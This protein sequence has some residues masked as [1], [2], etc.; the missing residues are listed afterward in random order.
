MEQQ[1]IIYL[2]SRYREGLITEQEHSELRLILSDEQH[3]ELISETILDDMMQMMAGEEVDKKRWE[4]LLQ[5]ILDIDT[6]KKHKPT[7]IISLPQESNSWDW[8]KIA[9]AAAVLLV[10]GVG[11]WFAIFDIKAD[12]D[13]I[14]STISPSD[15]K[16][17]ELNR[18]MI[19]MANGEKIFLDSAAEG[20]LV[21]INGVQV[22]KLADGQISYQH[23][24]LSSQSEM[25]FNTLSNPKGSKVIDITL[26]DGSRVWLNAASSL[27]YPIAFT[28]GDR[29]VKVT[30]EA[31]FEVSTAVTVKGVKQSFSVEANGVETEV[32]GT[33]FNV[34][35]YEDENDIRVTLIEGSV[36]VS[37]VRG[38][39]ELLKP[40]QQALI[41]SDRIN[42]Q[43]DIDTDEVMAWK[44]G[45]FI[46]GNKADIE[47]IMR[48]VSRWYNVEVV[49]RGSVSSHFWG[50][51]SRSVNISS[52]LQ[53]LEA[54]GAVK[55]KVE[56]NKVIVM[57]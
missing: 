5:L 27:T 19:T 45:K 44:D 21:Q 1:R 9:V 46:F 10:I 53:M 42:V 47:T 18:A 40:G 34:N 33:H 22:V 31:Y 6:T 12:N 25:I 39:S 14:Q 29:K 55:F 57:P 20:T 41:I 23:T 35:A 36:K 2:V 49:Y 50:S 51:I 54:T 4:P 43:L 8:K 30:G 38:K 52:V 24:A 11:G 32:L 15:V 17:P 13:I 7:K 56:G 37:K 48:Q 28:G 16:A 3:K 26:S